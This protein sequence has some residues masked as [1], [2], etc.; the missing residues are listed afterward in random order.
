MSEPVAHRPFTEPSPSRLAPGHPRRAEILTAH[1]SAMAAGEDG[2]LDPESG[3]FVLTAA[4]LAAKGTCCQSGC[5][6]C[7][8]VIG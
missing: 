5:R 4:F 6:H 8:F 3:L 7:P 2:Y 1:A